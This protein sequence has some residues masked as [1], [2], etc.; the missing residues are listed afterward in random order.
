MNDKPRLIIIEDDDALRERLIEITTYPPSAWIK[1]TAISGFVV[2]AVD[3]AQDGKDLIIKHS[4]EQPYEVILLDLKLPATRE[5]ANNEEKMDPE[6]GRS[7]LKYIRSYSDTAVVIFTAYPSEKNYIY[8]IQHGASDFMIKETMDRE[9]E[10]ILFLRLVK[11]A[12][13]TREARYRAIRFERQINIMLEEKKKAHRVI[14]K[15]I[16]GNASEISQ[17]ARGALDLLKQRYG[18]DPD[19]DK[20]DPICDS[21]ADIRRI[22]GEMVQAIWRES[23]GEKEKSRFEEIDVNT[24]IRQEISR[25]RPCYLHHGVDLRVSPH[26]P[27]LSIKTIEPDLRNL[28]AELLC[29]ALAACSENDVVEILASLSENKRDI[30]IRMTYPGA[31]PPKELMTTL[32]EG[33]MPSGT[34]DE[35][36]RGLVFLWSVARNMG[37]RVDVKSKKQKNDITLLIPVID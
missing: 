23:E 11:A 8:A 26:D 21:L 20:G 32:R 14:S 6:H 12:G 28:I 19:R 29:G 37:I 30:V 5:A 1:D 4:K 22:T 18:L 9:T 7:L 36:G 16:S 34:L 25:I 31:P 27:P 15:D 24:I 35:R 2:D 33:V 3:N 13:V 17:K 10:H